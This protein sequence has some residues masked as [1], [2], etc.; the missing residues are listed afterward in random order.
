MS[1][2]EVIGTPTAGK[3]ASL[4]FRLVLRASQPIKMSKMFLAASAMPWMGS[5]GDV[6]DALEGR[7]VRKLVRVT[8]KNFLFCVKAKLVMLFLV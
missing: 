7:A 8:Y 6:C 3:S 5:A 1:P 2:R 4:T